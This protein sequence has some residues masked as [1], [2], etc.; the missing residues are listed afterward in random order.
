MENQQSPAGAR[1]IPIRLVLAIGIFALPVLVT[2]VIFTPFIF[3][4]TNLKNHLKGYIIPD[5][6]AAADISRVVRQMR[7]DREFLFYFSTINDRQIGV[8][9]QEVFTLL[10]GIV[11]KDILLATVREQNARVRSFAALFSHL[12]YPDAF[13]NQ[14]EAYPQ[15]GNALKS[16]LYEEFKL[17]VMGLIYK[18]KYDHEFSFQWDDTSRLAATHLQ[19]ILVKLDSESRRKLNI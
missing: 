17:S 4:K 15:L 13:F 1:K 12:E 9:E 10:D 11:S 18:A 6:F 5:Q 2:V 7:D 8:L 3:S 16:L 14:P 19:E